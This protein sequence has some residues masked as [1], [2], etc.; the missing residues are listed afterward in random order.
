MPS[1][2]LGMPVFFG[3]SA[4]FI[5]GSALPRESIQDGDGNCTQRTQKPACL[6]ELFTYK[7]TVNTGK[8]INPV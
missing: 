5:A 8:Y 3:E 1:I 2:P 4:L 6:L 7:G